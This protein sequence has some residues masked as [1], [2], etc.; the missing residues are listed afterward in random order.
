MALDEVASKGDWEAWLLLVV[1]GGVILLVV[2][3]AR[4][5]GSAIMLPFMLY[6]P[7]MPVMTFGKGVEDIVGGVVALVGSRS[8]ASLVWGI[9][10][11]AIGLVLGGIGGALVVAGGVLG[12]IAKYV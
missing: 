11:V 7:M 3:L 2:G 12:L 10:L 5:L 1:V 6:M 8:V 4:V 9:V